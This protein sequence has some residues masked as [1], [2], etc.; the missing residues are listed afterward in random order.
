M[1]MNAVLSVVQEGWKDLSDCTD[2]R[3]GRRAWSP[4][5]SKLPSSKAT[6]GA[7]S[8]APR[9]LPQV[10]QNAGKPPL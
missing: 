10:A 6:V 1:K 9:E 2:A 5:A 8:M 4:L 7:S 3:A